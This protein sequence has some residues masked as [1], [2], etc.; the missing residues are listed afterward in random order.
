MDVLGDLTEAL[1]ALSQCRGPLQDPFSERAIP[2]GQARDEQN[3]HRGRVPCVGEVTPVPIDRAAKPFLVDL[4]QLAWFDGREA[5]RHHVQQRRI[6][7]AHSPSELVPEYRR[8]MPKVGLDAQSVQEMKRR[9]VIHHKDVECVLLR[10]LEDRVVVAKQDH[11]GDPVR[12]EFVDMLVPRLDPDGKSFQ[13]RNV[14]DAGN[15]VAKEDRRVDRGVWRRE[16]K[17]IRRSTV[18]TM[19]S[20]TSNSPARMRRNA[21]PQS[22]AWSSTL[23]P[24]FLSHARH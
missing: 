13:R 24:V 20:I 12:L 19:E 4:L 11:G 17:V 5:R 10:R 15:V 21:S 1:F 9:R 16:I 3:R 7:F 14:C 8:R 23:I 2:P 18:S 6:S 22:I